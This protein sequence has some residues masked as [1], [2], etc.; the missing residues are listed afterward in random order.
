MCLVSGSTWGGCGVL[1]WDLEGQGVQLAP[2]TTGHTDDY[3]SLPSW[4][5][6]REV[7]AVGLLQEV[8]RGHWPCT[9]PPSPAPLHMVSQ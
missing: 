1:E 4:K 9:D 5:T 8:Q 6:R 7:R 2:P 3:R